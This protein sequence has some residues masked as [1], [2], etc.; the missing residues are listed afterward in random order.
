MGKKIKKKIN[1]ASLVRLFLF[2]LVLTPL[3][4][5]SS[6]RLHQFVFRCDF[7]NLEYPRL[8]PSLGS[9]PYIPSP[10]PPAAIAAAA[11]VAFPNR[12]FFVFILSPSVPARS[13]RLCPSSSPPPRRPAPLALGGQRFG[14]GLN[15]VPVRAQRPRAHP[16]G[17]L[18]LHHETGASD[19]FPH[20]AR[21]L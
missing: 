11:D 16:E 9:V 1:E 19:G 7:Y 6:H 10:L 12:R 21:P 14:H 13:N 2:S 18:H 15:L 4:N 8:I 20:G 17:L 3:V 5:P